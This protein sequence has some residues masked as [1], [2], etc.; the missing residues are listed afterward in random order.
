LRIHWL[1]NFIGPKAWSKSGPDVF[2][3]ALV[4]P[5]GDVPGFF[6]SHHIV[7]RI[8]HGHPAGDFRA[9]WSARRARQQQCRIDDPLFQESPSI[10]RLLAVHWIA[11][12]RTR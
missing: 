2:A 6:I 1:R 12:T 3:D 11:C 8:V 5:A 10:G 7:V 9:S 4:P